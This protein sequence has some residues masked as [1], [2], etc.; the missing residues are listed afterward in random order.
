MKVKSTRLLAHI[1]YWHGLGSSEY[2]AGR[3]LESCVEVIHKDIVGVWNLLDNDKVRF[4]FCLGCLG[5]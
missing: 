1:G 3:S 2:F 5:C 4:L